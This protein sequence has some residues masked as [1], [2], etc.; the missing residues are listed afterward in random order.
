MIWLSATNLSDSEVDG[1]TTLI[2]YNQNQTCIPTCV[3]FTETGESFI[4][5]AA[6]H[7][8]YI[9]PQRTICNLKDLL[10]KSSN[11]I[12]DQTHEAV[13]DRE[14]PVVQISLNEE[15][16]IYS[17]EQLAGLFFQGVK[18]ISEDFMGQEVSET[19]VTVGLASTDLEKV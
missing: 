1:V 18:N 11:N 9:Q 17:P 16:K 19:I 14:V 5:E 3:A 8:R 15:T 2:P 4:G 12:G 10:R 7:Q 13:D 6:R